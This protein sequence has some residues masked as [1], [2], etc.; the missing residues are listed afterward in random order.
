[1]KLATIQDLEN[2]RDLTDYVIVRVPSKMNDRIGSLYLGLDPKLVHRGELPDDEQGTDFFNETHHVRTSAIVIN[3]P[4]HLRPVILREEYL[5]TPRYSPRMDHDD[6]R[7]TFSK[8]PPKERKKLERFGNSFYRCGNPPDAYE[9]QPDSP[10]VRVGDTV[11]FE[12]ATLLNDA[13][14][15]DTD[16]E[17]MVYRVPYQSIYCYVREGRITMIN[18]W[19]FVEPTVKEHVTRNIIMVNNKPQ[20]NIGKIAHISEWGKTFLPKVGD[21]CLFIR[22]LFSIKDW[23]SVADGHEISGY[24][25]EG[26]HYYPMR[27]WEIVAVDDNGSWRLK[28]GYISVKPETIN[29]INGVDTVVYDPSKNQVLK[30]GQLFIPPGSNVQTKEKKIH[31]YGIGLTHDGERIVYG[32]THNYL[33]MNDIGTLFIHNKDVWGLLSEEVSIN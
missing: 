33:Y 32:K 3:A 30:K 22:T 24:Q 27:N 31:H 4:S 11:H 2:A 21:S 28:N 7:Y 9:A 15:I 8:M 5:G 29:M 12:Y 13:N 23:N 14:R 26:S 16:G 25:V 18:G 1:M 6:I 19:V 17:G 20:P 10:E